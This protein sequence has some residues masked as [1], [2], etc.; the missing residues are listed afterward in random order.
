MKTKAEKSGCYFNTDEVYFM[1]NDRDSKSLSE[2]NLI[3]DE[4]A[5]LLLKRYYSGNY[6]E[7]KWN[8]H[9]EHVFEML[10][11]KTLS[12]I[13]INESG[14]IIKGFRDCKKKN[15]MCNSYQVYTI[16]NSFGQ[17]ETID[18]FEMSQFLNGFLNSDNKYSCVNYF[19]EKSLV[20]VLGFL[21][22]ISKEYTTLKEI[23]LQVEIYRL[24]NNLKNNKL[25]IL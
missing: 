15:A 16:E 1:I 25:T 8:L 6:H 12:P 3:T 21:K 4:N 24:Q 22:R 11:P 5:F 23:K 7:T 19:G 13:E 14:F 17:I 20:N 2:T 9:A 10:C 18:T